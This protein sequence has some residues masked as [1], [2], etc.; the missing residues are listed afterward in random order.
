MNKIKVM[1]NGLPGNMATK[2]VECLLKDNRFELIPRSLTGP[3]IKTD[4]FWVGGGTIELIPP[5]RREEILPLF[6]RNEAFIS[7]DF[8]QPAA[9]NSNAEFYCLY[10]LPFVMGTTGGNREWLSKTVE[11]S[12]TAAVIAPNIAKQ[13]VGFQA[14]MEYAASAF[15]EMFAGYSLKIRESHQSG[16]A[17]TSGT[18]KAMVQCFNKLGV[19]FNES[20]IIKERDPDAQRTLGVPEQY[21]A[22]HGWHTY[23]LV[24]PDQTV[25]L[26]LTHNVNGRDIYAKGTLDAIAFLSRKIEEGVKGKVFTMIDVL[27]G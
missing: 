1:V 14:M 6:L 5:N 9:V 21:L 10:E 23:A 24:S 27:K 8:T 7:V 4:L 11:A 22:G 25:A 20:Q 3:E 12:V 26:E 18:A 2:V 15:P 16:K 13:V 17:D 19:P